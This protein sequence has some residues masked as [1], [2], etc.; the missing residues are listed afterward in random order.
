MRRVALQLLSAA[1]R[2]MLS[3]LAIDAAA[4]NGVEPLIYRL[5]TLRMLLYAD[6]SDTCTTAVVRNS[7]QVPT[8]DMISWPWDGR[9]L[10][11]ISFGFPN[12]IVSVVIQ[13][14]SCAHISRI[15][16]LSVDS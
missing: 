2:S 14:V 5:K 15:R 4:Y 6:R 13:P 10:I 9:S 16:L 8:P 7:Q 1:G 3:R 12:Q 11:N